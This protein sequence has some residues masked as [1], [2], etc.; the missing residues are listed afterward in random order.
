MPIKVL[1]FGWELPPFNSGGL[2]TACYGLSEA[3]ANQNVEITFVLPQKVNIK[4]DF[5]RL[6]FAD[7]EGFNWPDFNPYETLKLLPPG[8]DPE[9]ARD[10]ISAVNMYARRAAAIARDGEFDLIHSHDWLCFPAGIV[11]SAVAHKPLITHVHATEMDRG[12]GNGTNPMV[13][14]VEKHGM[15]KSSAIIAVSQFTKNLLKMYYQVHPEK[16]NVVHNGVNPSEFDIPVDEQNPLQALKDAGFKIVLFVGRLTLQKG[17]DYLLKAAKR[18]LEYYPNAVFLFVGSG[19]MEN[20]LI[21]QTVQMGLSDR[22]LFAG[23]LRGKMLSQSFKAADLFIMPSVS[24]PFG[25]TALESVAA[26]TPAI[27]SRQSGAS[28]ALG[29]VLKVDFWDVEEMANQIVS[30][31]NYPS[32]HNSLKVNGKNEVKKVSWAAAAA[33]TI[34]VYKKVLSRKRN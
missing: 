2:G 17:P 8:I 34:E 23:F 25:I 7:L 14:A 21:N 26:G 28:E 18:T 33:K 19:D 5:M 15:D 24:E 9:V 20:Q 22:V 32:L 27:I 3:L 16:I 6:V 30:V 10:L 31:L 12:G 11:A 1:M 13:Y 4:A 29:H